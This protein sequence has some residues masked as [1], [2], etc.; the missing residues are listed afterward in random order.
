MC[1]APP[2]VGNFFDSFQLHSALRKRYFGVAQQVKDR[3][4]SVQWLGSLLWCRFSPWPGNFHVPWVWTKKKPK[5][6]FSFSF[7]GLTLSIGKFQG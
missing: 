7:K 5:V 3:V 4:L 6:L 2:A 1:Q